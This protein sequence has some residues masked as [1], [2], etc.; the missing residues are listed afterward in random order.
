MFS[1]SRVIA[2]IHLTN[3]FKLDDITF[4]LSSDIKSGLIFNSRSKAFLVCNVDSRALKQVLHNLKGCDHLTPVITSK[5]SCEFNVTISEKCPRAVAEQIEAIN[6]RLNTFIKSLSKSKNRFTE[7]DVLCTHLSSGFNECELSTDTRSLV[8][9]YPLYHRFQTEIESVRTVF[10]QAVTISLPFTASS[11]KGLPCVENGLAALDYKRVRRD[12]EID[13]KEFNAEVY[14]REELT[15]RE[16][17]ITRGDE[18]LAKFLYLA[19][20]DIPNDAKEVFDELKS[21]YLKKTNPPK[22]KKDKAKFSG[23]FRLHMR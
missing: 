21:Q 8:A 19:Y 16:D 10:G 12:Q 1:P 17:L 20:P 11:S 9:I 5:G 7:L 6:S 3:E 14:A 15:M 23:W 13:A 2:R 18:K 4:R 22:T